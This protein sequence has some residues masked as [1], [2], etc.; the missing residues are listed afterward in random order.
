MRRYVA[1]LALIAMIARA[2]I[3]TGFMPAVVHGK[4]QLMICHGGAHSAVHH[5][6]RGHAG[7]H[8]NTPCPFA[9]SGGP[10]PL[11]ATI[12]FSL[13]H[14]APELATVSPEPAALP[15]APARYAA[16]RGPPSLV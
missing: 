2:L 9:I 15:E 5:G 13:V 4:A 11:P 1:T 6:D 8:A 12:D 16:P 7:S 14:N 3:P 10:A